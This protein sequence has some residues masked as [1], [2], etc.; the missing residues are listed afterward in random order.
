MLGQGETTKKKTWHVQGLSLALF[1]EQVPILSFFISFGFSVFCI[2]TLR[3][4]NILFIVPPW[5]NHSHSFIHAILKP[6]TC[7]LVLEPSETNLVVELHMRLADSGIWHRLPRNRN[8]GQWR[9]E[10]QMRN[11]WPA[12][13]LCK[14]FCRCQM[15]WNVLVWLPCRL[16]WNVLAGIP[17]D[18]STV[19]RSCSVRSCSV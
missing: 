11:R 17:T 1:E 2:F 5:Q 6:D 7:F 12:V 15:E 14:S 3:E 19:R 10:A 18:L 13:G 9:P 16:W 8:A 4:H